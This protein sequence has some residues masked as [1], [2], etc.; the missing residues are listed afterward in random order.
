V[1]A[2]R[3]YYFK[4]RRGDVVVEMVIWQL[5]TPSSDRPHG[6]KYRL[7]CGRGVACVVRYDNEIGKGDHC[8]YGVQE[9]AYDFVSVDKLIEDFRRDCARLAGWSWEE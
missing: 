8:H 1:R 5:A 6:L 9:V 2:R 4:H 7:Y 3:L